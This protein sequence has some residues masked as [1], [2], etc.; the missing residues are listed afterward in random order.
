[1]NNEE[2]AR[3]AT[4]FIVHSFVFAS[5]FLMRKNGFSNNISTYEIDFDIL[6]CSYSH[7]ML[8]LPH[9]NPLY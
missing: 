5:L 6:I 3:H 8:Y 7:F 9:I 2:C 1:M 4:L